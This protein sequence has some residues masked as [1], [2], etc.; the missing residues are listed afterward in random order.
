MHSRCVGCWGIVLL[1]LACAGLPDA[2]GQNPQGGNAGLPLRTLAPG[3]LQV[4][5][6]GGEGGD[7]YVGP[8]PLPGITQRLSG[9]DWNPNFEPKS[10]TLL[11]RAKAVVY[12]HPIWSLEFAFKPL[13]MIEVDVPQPS[14]GTQRKQIWYLVYRVRNVGYDLN[15]ELKEPV[16]GLKA[17]EIELVNYA[18][19]R[20]FPHFVLASHEFD[21]QYLDRVIP[22]AKRPIQ[23]RE[24][25]GVEMYNSVEMTQVKIP[26]SDD[27]AD[28]SVWGFATWEDIDPRID[29]FSI[30]VRGL[31]NAFRVVDTTGTDQPGAGRQHAF[32][33]LQLNF[34]RPGD[35]QYQHEREIQYGV[36]IETDPAKQQAVLEK[37]GLQQRLDY[38]WVYR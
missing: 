20:F 38:R 10:Q 21:V 11:E 18:T 19:R 3:V 14:G 29:F 33:V 24:N 34:W 17:P 28:R 30:Y 35:T 15:P 23:L 12:H 16:P 27:L 25:P 32:K 26:L 36:P 5:P 8:V 22:A 6:P 7:T 9:L 4:I 31:T 1:V 13:R 37:Y 2:Y